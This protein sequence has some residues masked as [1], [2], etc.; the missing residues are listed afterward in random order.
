[1]KDYI[2]LFLVYSSIFLFFTFFFVFS[3][4]LPILISQKVL[5]YRG[6]TLLFIVLFFLLFIVFFL[7][8]K[9]LNFV[10][11]QTL[12]AALLISFSF[13]LTF[14]VVF[15]VT[16]DRSVTMF[17]LS[18]LEDNK[19]NNEEKF[20]VSSREDYVG[21]YVVKNKAIA[22]RIKEQSIIGMLTEDN[23]GYIDILDRGL[24]FLVLSRII[25][26]L[27]ALN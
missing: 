5:F 8:R 20:S 19:K 25:G 14:F 15:P 13:N 1:M 18:S 3:F 7:K 11:Y 27:F 22:R 9:L 10:S 4:H 21:I 6:I 23:N 2:K 12:I 24:S 16:F 17:L 26:K